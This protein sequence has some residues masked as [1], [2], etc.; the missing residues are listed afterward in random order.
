MTCLKC[1]TVIAKLSVLLLCTTVSYGVKCKV[2]IIGKVVRVKFYLPTYCLLIEP[3]EKEFL[4]KPVTKLLK[5]LCRND[6]AVRRCL[7]LS[8]LVLLQLWKK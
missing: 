5:F 1:F 2:L 4:A 6:C 3:N 8:D 7:L